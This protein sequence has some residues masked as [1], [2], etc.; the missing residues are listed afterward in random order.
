MVDRP[1]FD[2]LYQPRMMG[3]DECGAHGIKGSVTLTS[4]SYRYVRFSKFFGSVSLILSCISAC[5]PSN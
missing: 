3:D 1:S 2:I 5:R 4:P